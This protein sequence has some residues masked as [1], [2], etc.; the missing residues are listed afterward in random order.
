MWQN[1]LLADYWLLNLIN[2]QFTNSFFD[3]F[4]PLI[5]DLHKT[6][7]FKVTVVPLVALLFVHRY[8]RQGITLFLF[9]LL[10]LGLSDFSG[11][12]IKYLPERPRPPKNNAIEVTQRS[13]AGGY[14]FYSNHAS[15]MFTLATYTSYFIPYMKIPL[16]LMAGAVTYSRVY[17]G[18]HY[19]S[20]VLA[21][22]LM[23][24][25]WGW[26]FS[27]LIHRILEKIRKTSHQRAAI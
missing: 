17:N 3:W 1:L 6:Q 4:F 12:R 10:A 8:R 5:T 26:F 25:F 7:Y 14:S 11:G 24:L 9:L 13:Q 15:N 20:D 27:R 23:G 18:V 19:P 16:F 21:G 2:T 22:A